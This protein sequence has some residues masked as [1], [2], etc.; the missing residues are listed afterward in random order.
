MIPRR[1]NEHYAGGRAAAAFEGVAMKRAL[2]VAAVFVLSALVW[3][4]DLDASRA[5]R[6]TS[7]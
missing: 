3:S 1:A 4:G 5:G 2:V 7:R 6:I